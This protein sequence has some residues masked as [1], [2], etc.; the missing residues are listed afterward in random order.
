MS[1][2]D[3]DSYDLRDFLVGALT[4]AVLVGFTW[5][6]VSLTSGEDS[7]TTVSEVDV[8]DTAELEDP[9]A[10][11]DRAAPPSKVEACHDVFEAQRPVLE[12]AV[13]PMEQWEVH[14]GAMNK[15]VVGAITLR[16]A[17]QFWNETRVGALRNLET[18]TAAR[19]DLLDRTYRCP[20]PQPGDPEDARSRACQDAVTAGARVAR[21]ASVALT[22]WE[23]HVHHMEMLR[24]GEMTPTEATELWLRSWQKGQEQVRAY[25]A[26]LRE[27]PAKRC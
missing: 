14:I 4:G 26:A 10:S 23:H 11:P 9:V 24:E 19:R 5:L 16:Q 22:T 13:A 12:A 6:G 8:G 17:N 15:L 7:T 1:R 20:P 3:S 21:R 18:F 25:R 27:A 2:G